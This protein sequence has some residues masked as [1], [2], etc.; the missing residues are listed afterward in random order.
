MLL[1]SARCSRDV[2]FKEWQVHESLHTLGHDSNAYNSVDLY[3][4]S[5]WFTFAFKVK[6]IDY[7]IKNIIK[8]SLSFVYIIVD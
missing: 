6:L 3:T 4:L 5:I 2:G 8:L 1:L 7:E